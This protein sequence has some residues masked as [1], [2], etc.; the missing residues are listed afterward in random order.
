MS[1]FL[2]SYSKSDLENID[3]ISNAL[4]TVLWNKPVPDASPPQQIE[5]IQ[6]EIF[7]EMFDDVGDSVSQISGEK[8]TKRDEEIR[9]TAPSENA[10]VHSGALL[11]ARA[12][13]LAIAKNA[14]RR[15][16]FVDCGGD[17]LDEPIAMLP[18][19]TSKISHSHLST[20]AKPKAIPNESSIEHICP[21]KL[22]DS[23]RRPALVDLNCTDRTVS[24]RLA[25][26]N[27]VETLLPSNSSSI[28]LSKTTEPNL[29]EKISPVPSKSGVVLS[30]QNYVTS[31]LS[32]FTQ[33]PIVQLPEKKKRIITDKAEK[34]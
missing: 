19:P 30:R 16:D 33:L 9:S 11:R 34:W 23:L 21:L 25:K 26:Q 7:H 20:I 5:D 10:S 8:P 6:E 13:Q 1:L 22:S 32:A 31:E 15:H 4:E 18:S 24:D 29:I 17:R 12:K 28:H 14:I 3:T 27:K 2:I